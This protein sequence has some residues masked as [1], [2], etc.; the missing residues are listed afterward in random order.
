MAQVFSVR[1]FC[2]LALRKIGAFAIADSGARAREVEVARHWLEMIVG[3]QAAKK[4]TWWL[5]PGTATLTLREGVASYDLTDEIGIAQ[6]PQGVEFVVSA[7]LYDTDT[8][9]L[10]HE[11]SLLPRTDWE[12]I[13]QRSREGEPEV[14]Y[15]NR[16]QRPTMLVSPVP[17]GVRNIEARIVFQSYAANFISAALTDR[18]TLG[19]RSSWN[20]WL[21][22]ALAAAI[23]NGPVRKLP[24]DE[25]KDM[26]READRL[27]AELEAYEDHDQSNALERVAFY[28]GV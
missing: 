6:A 15:I 24:A 27:L 18:T 9:D 26:R 10:I 8:G 2:E 20:L 12:D 1:Q 16:E 5:V 19:I 25:V 4:R 17:N 21:V 13:T 3:H 7:H 14:A 23:G 28:G 11:I 22:A